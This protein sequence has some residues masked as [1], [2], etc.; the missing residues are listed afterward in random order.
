MVPALGHV[1]MEGHVLVMI[2]V[3]GRT[4]FVIH[5]IPLARGRETICIIHVLL[6]LVVCL[7]LLASFFLPSH[8]SVKHVHT[9]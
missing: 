1:G 9:M 7:T 6:C 2:S 8:L 4:A 5:S 3:R